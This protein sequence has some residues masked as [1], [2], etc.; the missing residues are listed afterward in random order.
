MGPKWDLP[1]PLR[2]PEQRRGLQGSESCLPC[3]VQGG[4]VGQVPRGMTTMTPRGEALT[5]I[6][7]IGDSP[8]LSAMEAQ[9]TATTTRGETLKPILKIGDSPPL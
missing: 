5:S 2:Q 9:R 4:S 8:P 7:K 1:H 6:L 3:R